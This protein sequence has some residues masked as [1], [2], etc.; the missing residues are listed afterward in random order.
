[1]HPSFNDPTRGYEMYP[2]GPK[3]LKVVGAHFLSF[4][5]SNGRVKKD[6]NYFPMTDDF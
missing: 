3:F 2:I 1:M 6:F 4:N 5:L